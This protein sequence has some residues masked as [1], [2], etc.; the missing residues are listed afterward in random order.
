MNKDIRETFKEK[1]FECRR[2]SE[3]IRTAKAY[4]SNHFPLTIDTYQSLNEVE[5]SFIDQMVFRFSKLQDTL[6]ER[7]FPSLL[8]LSGEEIKRK[9][10][11]DI[12]NRLE[13]LT[14]VNKDQWLILRETRNEIAH[15]YSDNTEEI[16]FSLN[17]VFE[18][19]E[20][21]I[22]VFENIL[23]FCADKLSIKTV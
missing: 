17:Q 2:H 16:V 20:E 19:S 15:E 23:K 21:T 1:L 4:I 6:G 12:V 11:I 7:I 5:A 8:L 13:E 18:K 22:Q 3:K 14:L 10:F 9:T